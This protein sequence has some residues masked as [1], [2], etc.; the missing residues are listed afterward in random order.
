MV[1]TLKTL[2]LVKTALILAAVFSSF[3]VDVSEAL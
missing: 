1:A 3:S 2:A